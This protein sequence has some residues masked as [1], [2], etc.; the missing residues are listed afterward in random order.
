MSTISVE[1][2]EQDSLGCLK[3]VEAGET[4]TVLRDNQQVA[5]IKPPSNAAQ[6][7]LPY[8]QGPELTSKRGRVQRP[9][10]RKRL[11]YGQPPKLMSPADIGKIASQPRWEKLLAELA[12]QNICVEVEPVCA[13]LDDFPDVAEA[14]IAICRSTRK[15]FGP[16]TPL[17]LE[18]NRDPEIDDRY[19]KLRVSLPDFSPD[20]DQRLRSVADAHAEQLWDKKGYILVTPHFPRVR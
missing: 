4:L 7:P 12:A 8:G 17:T 19:L 18:I 5:E 16:D 2:M 10:R 9:K 1:E 3:R 20:I 14:L 15:E 11:P 6:P 13:Y